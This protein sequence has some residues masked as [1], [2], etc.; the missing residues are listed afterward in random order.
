MNSETMKQLFITSFFTFIAF[1]TYCQCDAYFNFQEGAE[2]EMTHYSAKDKISG[3]SLSQIISIEDNNG[4]ITA[5]IKGTMLDKK[6][7]EST[8][9]T[10]EYICD[11][12]ILKIDMEKFIPKES[13]GSDS[14]IEFDMKGDYLEIPGNL[15]VGQELKDGKIEGKMTMGDNSAMA[16]M[17]M[18]ISIFNRKVVSRE[19]ITTPAGTF[20][21]YKISYDMESATKVMGM[22]TKVS[23]KGVEYVAKGVGVIKTES[24]NKNGKL[25]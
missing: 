15:E 9:F 20:S 22:N 2:Y 23:L 8:S 17:T 14:N 3:K 7:E 5:T 12:G 6:G 21:C 24:Y 1:Y 18:T 13:F 11:N 19:D 4:V 25:S 10:Y 16:N